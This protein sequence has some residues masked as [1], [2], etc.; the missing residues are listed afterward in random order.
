MWLEV[1]KGRFSVDHAVCGIGVA[2]VGHITGSL[3]LSE[4]CGSEH[5]HR[6]TAL[7]SFFDLRRHSAADAGRDDPQFVTGSESTDTK[8]HAERTLVIIAIVQ[9][10]R[11]VEVRSNRLTAADRSEG[12]GILGELEV[13]DQLVGGENWVRIGRA[14]GAA[15]VN[16]LAGGGGANNS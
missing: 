9:E 2:A 11:I 13:V 12:A 1:V 4:S 8:L 16:G 5:K 3:I 6:N 10:L 14:E 7:L 15:D